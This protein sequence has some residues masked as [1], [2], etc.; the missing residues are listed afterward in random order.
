MYKRQKPTRFVLKLVMPEVF[1]GENLG[2]CERQPSEDALVQVER[3]LPEPV[4]YTHLD[5][6]KRQYYDRIERP[7]FEAIRFIVEWRRGKADVQN[8]QAPDSRQ[9]GA[10]GYEL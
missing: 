6:Y 3:S 7:R 2:R 5:V 1:I 4:S 8:V 9:P 10:C